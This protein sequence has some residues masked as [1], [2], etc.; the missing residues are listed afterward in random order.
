[1]VFKL[2]QT[3]RYIPLHCYH[4]VADSEGGARSTRLFMAE[5]AST[6][7]AFKQMSG[8]GPT[9]PPP[10]H[11]HPPDRQSWIRPCDGKKGLFVCHLLSTSFERKVCLPSPQHIIFHQLL[12]VKRGICDTWSRNETHCCH[13]GNSFSNSSIGSFICTF[14]KT[15]CHLPLPLLNLMWPTGWNEK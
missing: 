13:I 2:F 3:P 1:M 10:S 11:L 5:I 12:G 7:L 8:G 14:L 15:E 9:E 6:A 4:A